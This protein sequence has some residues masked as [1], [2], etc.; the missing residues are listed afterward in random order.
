MF[1]CAD[2]LHHTWA[3]PQSQKV[4][5]H[6]LCMAVPFLPTSLLLSFSLKHARRHIQMRA[7]RR[8]LDDT[9]SKKTETAS[10][11]S[12]GGFVSHSKPLLMLKRSPPCLW[13]VSGPCFLV[14]SDVSD[15]IAERENCILF[16][17]RLQYA[18][19]P[20]CSPQLTTHS[21]RTGARAHKDTHRWMRTHTN[22]ARGLKLFL[23]PLLPWVFPQYCDTLAWRDIKKCHR[24]RGSDFRCSLPP[25]RA[26]GMEAREG[27]RWC[28]TMRVNS[29]LRVI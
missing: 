17:Q 23:T 25:T 12:F 26:E 4:R 9:Q 1:A 22:L 2:V 13:A 11:L 21:A 8:S 19:F 3:A 20:L 28:W 6:L 18:T 10:L 29:A 14:P 7:G 24:F 16:T 15:S 5:T 27:G